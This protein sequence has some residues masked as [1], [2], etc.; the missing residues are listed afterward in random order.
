MIK[1]LIFDFDGTVYD[2]EEGITKSV[3]YAINKMGLDEPLSSLRR[4][5]GPPL[6]DMF[7]REFDLSAE[8]AAQ[9]VTVFRERYVPIGVYESRVFPGMPEL[10]RDL[11]KAGFQ[12]GIATSKPQAMVRQL[13]DSSDIYKYFDAITGS[14][15]GAGDDSKAL[16]LRRTMEKLRADKDNTLL[17][18]DTKWDVFGARECG[19]PCVGV[20]YG[21]GGRAEL[22]ASGA[23]FIVGDMNDLREFLLR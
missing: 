10:L 2:T 23:E 22:E 16:V 8:A 5:C 11:K 18:G 19:V 9:A 4:F 3:R 1:N 12:L 15:P 6:Q 13:L 21:Y 17:I 7:M 14:T 20:E